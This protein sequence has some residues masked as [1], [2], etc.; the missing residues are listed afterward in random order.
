MG[1][2]NSLTIAAARRGKELNTSHRTNGITS[3]GHNENKHTH[4]ALRHMRSM[5]ARRLHGPGGR[6][7]NV[8]GHRAGA[9]SDTDDHYGAEGFGEMADQPRCEHESLG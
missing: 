9:R 6:C 8:P 3:Y 5:A 1:H 2:L 7:Q 4:D